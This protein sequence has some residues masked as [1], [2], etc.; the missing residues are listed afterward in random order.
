MA[1]FAIEIRLRHL[2]LKAFYYTFPV[3]FYEVYSTSSVPADSDLGT[4]EATIDAHFF[5]Q[6]VFK[7]YCF[8]RFD[9]FSLLF[10]AKELLANKV[11]AFLLDISRFAYDAILVHHV[12]RFDEF[13][14]SRIYITLV[15]IISR[16]EN[17]P[18]TELLK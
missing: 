1:M 15:R 8:C 13:E 10:L 16:I 12:M 9:V 6:C 14:I 2:Y 3:D 18:V 7:L 5:H 11:Y 4:T 17:T